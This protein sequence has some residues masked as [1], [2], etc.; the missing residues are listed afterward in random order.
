MDNNSRRMKYHAQN[1]PV[2]NNSR[3][4]CSII[5]SVFN[6]IVM[7]KSARPARAGRTFL[8]TRYRRRVLGT[9]L[10]VQPKLHGMREE[11]QPLSLSLSLSFSLFLAASLSLALSIENRQTR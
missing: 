11:R 7:E 6:K 10:S 3:S 2:E 4:M 8:S 5:R 1:A 9:M